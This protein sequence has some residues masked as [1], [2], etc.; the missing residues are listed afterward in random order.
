MSKLD[1]RAGRES[2]ASCLVEGTGITRRSLFSALAGVGV[3]AAT[4]NV[5]QAQESDGPAVGDILVNSKG[6][7]VLTPADV[8]PTSKTV[9]IA[10]AQ[11][12]SGNVKKGNKNKIALVKV[13]PAKIGS[14]SEGRGADGLLAYSAIC[15][16]AGCEVKAWLPD[17]GMMRCP[18]HG[19]EFDPANNGVVEKGPA[20]HRLASLV[21]AV[22]NDQIVIKEGFDADVGAQG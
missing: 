10:Y 11:D 12:A 16:H 6:G 14:E 3:L 20:K 21:I 22:E 1:P 2:D 4:G 5:V 15:T 7:A 13:D 17:S 8:D 18:C 9:I 19:S